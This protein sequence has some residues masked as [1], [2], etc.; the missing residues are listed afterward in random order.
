MKGKYNLAIKFFTE[1]K[2][3]EQL[4]LS[5]KEIDRFLTTYDNFKFYLNFSLENIS[6]FV[7]KELSDEE[8]Y[9]KKIKLN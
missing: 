5:Y 9:N 3:E 2:N 1:S 7:M 4:E 8:K 6:D